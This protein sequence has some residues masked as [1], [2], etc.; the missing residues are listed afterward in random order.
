MYSKEVSQTREAFWTR[1]GQYMSP[2]LSAEGAKFNWI[3]Y[4]TGQKII[5][6]KMRADKHKGRISIQISHK[7]LSVQQVYFEQFQALNKILHAHLGE[8]WTWNFRETDVYGK[9]S[10]SI[11]KV[12]QPLN[13]YKKEDWPGLISF[14][15]PRIIALDAF[16]SEARYGFEE[17]S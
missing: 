5:S 1:F 7:E 14:F 3:N 12:S 6:F 9:L 16:W 8:Q 17:F 4:K 15:K 2:V 11:F 10:C 13:L